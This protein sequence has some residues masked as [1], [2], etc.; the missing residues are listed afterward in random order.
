MRR[1]NPIKMLHFSWLAALLVFAIASAKT[2][3]LIRCA[4]QPCHFGKASPTDR[5]EPS[6]TPPCH[7]ERQDKGP[8][9]STTC[10]IS[11]FAENRT[12]T[13]GASDIVQGF[14]P[15]ALPSRSLRMPSLVIF[16]DF[17][18]AQASPA[19]AGLA[20]FIVLRI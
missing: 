12:R 1:G 15:V 19:S 8:S 3:C 2:Q 5:P 14:G 16:Q 11:M 9:P 4:G 13:A 17:V 7:G 18:P 20:R 10:E 6:K